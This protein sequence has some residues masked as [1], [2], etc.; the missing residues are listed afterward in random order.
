[1]KY[2]LEGPGSLEIAGDTVILRNGRTEPIV[3]R[4]FRVVPR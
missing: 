3:W 1:L 2:E 4:N